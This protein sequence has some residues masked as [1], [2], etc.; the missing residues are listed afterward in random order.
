MQRSREWR[1]KEMVESVDEE[2]MTVFIETPDCRRTVLSRYLDHDS[3]AENGQVD[4]LGTDSIFGSQCG[5]GIQSSSNTEFNGD[6][7]KY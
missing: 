4:Y 6:D 5:S 1:R 3:C 7:G 2:A